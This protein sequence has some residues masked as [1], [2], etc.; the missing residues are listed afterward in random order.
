[1]RTRFEDVV[2]GTNRKRWARDGF[3]N[4]NKTYRIVLH[5]IQ[6]SLGLDHGHDNGRNTDN[7]HARE[8]DHLY[9]SIQSYTGFVDPNTVFATPM[10]DDIHALQDICGSRDLNSKSTIYTFK[11]SI[12]TILDQD[13]SSFLMIFL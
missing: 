1:M 7:I 6:H 2:N 4:S 9:N 13:H 11:R 12:C 3:S 5:E 8:S 10:P